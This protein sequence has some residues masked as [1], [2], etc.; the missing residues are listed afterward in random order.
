M[1]VVAVAAGYPP[2]R[3]SAAQPVG[4]ALAAERRCRRHR[5]HRRRPRARNPARRLSA[6]IVPDAVRA[7]AHRVVLARPPRHPP[8]RRTAR[9]RGRYGAACAAT[10]RPGYRVHRGDAALWQSPAAGRMDQRGVRRGVHAGC[11]RSGGRTPSSAATTAAGSSAA[12][13]ACE[14]AGSSP[15]SRCSTSRRMRRR[16][17]LIGLVDWLNDT[18]GEAARRAVADPAP[19]LD[20]SDLRDT[21]TTTSG[22]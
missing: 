18:G 22:D 5:R 20:G 15:A 6:R 16:S 17:R 4:A 1:L 13:T 11:T 9:A 10:A 8:P 19:D 7:Q 21:V 2:P 14:S 12:C 3:R